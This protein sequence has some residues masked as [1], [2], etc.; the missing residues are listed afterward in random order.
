MLHSYVG[1]VSFM[2][3]SFSQD[4]ATSE[5]GWLYL[6]WKS[7]FWFF[8][9]V[10]RPQ[11]SGIGFPELNQHLVLRWVFSGQTFCTCKVFK[12]A[13]RQLSPG[14]C[15]RVWI[16][17]IT[18]SNLF[19]LYPLVLPW[20]VVFFVSL[21]NKATI[22][23]SSHEDANNAFW[24]SSG[25]LKASAFTIFCRRSGTTPSETLR[26]DGYRE[27]STPGRSSDKKWSERKQMRRHDTRNNDI[28]DDVE[29]S[30]SH[31][32]RKRRIVL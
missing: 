4:A 23:F 22:S 32:R 26:S 15:Q 12:G 25:N 5:G 19:P 24:N 11:K 21:G 28:D 8:F 3:W 17:S 7:C 27:R 31:H 10:R 20:V 30:R 16:A 13:L 14:A 6:V 2:R 18:G 29:S 1:W 9:S